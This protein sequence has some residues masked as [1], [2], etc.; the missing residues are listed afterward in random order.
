MSARVIGPSIPAQGATSV[1]RADNGPIIVA[2]PSQTRAWSAAAGELPATERRARRF[3]R[4]PDRSGGGTA[5]GCSGQPDRFASLAWVESDDRPRPNCRPRDA[6][7]SGR[8]ETRPERVWTGCPAGYLSLMRIRISARCV[9]S[10][11]LSAGTD[12]GG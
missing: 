2:E 5:P 9:P 7:A 1:L 4:Q 3:P 8:E 10:A 6:I 11:S 12:R